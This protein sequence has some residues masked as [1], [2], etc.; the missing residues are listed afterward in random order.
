LI[1][2]KSSDL[3]FIGLNRYNFIKLPF[4]VTFF[5]RLCSE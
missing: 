3:F 2:L 1:A 5:L 4:A